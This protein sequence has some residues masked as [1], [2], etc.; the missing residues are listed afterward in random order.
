VII[1]NRKVIFDDFETRLDKI[2]EEGNPTKAQ[3]F[4]ALHKSLNVYETTQTVKKRS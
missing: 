2:F 1:T 3:I 4:D